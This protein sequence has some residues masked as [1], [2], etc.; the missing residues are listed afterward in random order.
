MS[1]RM[2]REEIKRSVLN[3]LPSLKSD[4]CDALSG[5]SRHVTAVPSC[6]AYQ[7]RMAQ[8][9]FLQEKSFSCDVG[10]YSNSSKGVN[11]FAADVQS[12]CDLFQAA[13]RRSNSTFAGEL[14]TKN[15]SAMAD[16]VSLRMEKLLSQ[17]HGLAVPDQAPTP[18]KKLKK[19]SS[20]E[21]S[22]GTSSEPGSSNEKNINIVEDLARYSIHMD[23]QKQA[24]A[25]LPM[26]G[27]LFW[28]TKLADC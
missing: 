12:V 18:G 15:A 22:P 24:A 20:A 2:M 14:N 17:H 7:S 19:G 21:S 28:M 16:L 13:S 9:E 11:A 23:I 6:V 8:A 10:V 27:K 5:C 3:P 1:K 4:G 25:L 26:M